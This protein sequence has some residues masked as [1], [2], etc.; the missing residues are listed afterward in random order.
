MDRT[1]DGMTT[2]TRLQGSLQD[3]GLVEVLQMMELSN[4]TGAIHL[5]QASGRTGIIYFNDGKMANCS[6][7]DPNALTLGDVLQQMGMAT[8]QQIEHAFYQQLQDAFGMRIGERLMAMGV[9]NDQQLKEALRTKALWTARDLAT[10][11]EGSYEFIPSSDIQAVLPY[12]ESS[13]ELEV[14]RVTMEM[15][16]YSDVWDTLKNILPNGMNTAL[17]MVQVIPYTV[18]LDIRTIELLGV[19]NVFHKVRKVATALRRPEQDVAQ[20]LGQLVQF[21]LLLP[22]QEQ[23]LP[24]Q[25]GRST[26]RLPDPAEKLRMESFELMNLVSR[27]EQE[28][29]R[30][31]T[32]TEQ[33]PALVE[34]INWT[35]D[36]LSETCRAN[37]TELDSNTLESLLTRKKLR[38]MGNYK[39][40]IEQNHIDVENFTALCFEVLQGDVQKSSDFFDEASIVLQRILGCIF[41]TINSRVASFVERMENREVW[42]ALFAQFALPHL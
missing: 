33:L 18:G 21:K 17:Q 5:K 15:V 24:S 11:Q 31:H 36:A 38:Y 26:V 14:M 40:I 32:P 20:E 9:I 34:F 19:V 22:Y 23:Q 25:Q 16:R 12:G 13:L 2:S 37:G 27:M 30:R 10:W 42:E 35:M 8:N 28:W 41:E 3:F 39:F 7:F 6:E 4:M 1:G 29:Y